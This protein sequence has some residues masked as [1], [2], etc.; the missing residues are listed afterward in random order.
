MK[1]N[2][3]DSLIFQ[4][5][6]KYF[7]SIFPNL[8]LSGNRKRK[9]REDGRV[10]AN[11]FII[12]IDSV[13]CMV[14]AAVTTTLPYYPLGVWRWLAGCKAAIAD[15]CYP[16]HHVGSDIGKHCTRDYQLQ[17]ALHLGG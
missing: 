10:A 2:I 4:G 13:P 3:S 11:R 16:L 6:W 1:T 14:V 7:L 17:G 8:E 12:D 5:E 9:K 15:K